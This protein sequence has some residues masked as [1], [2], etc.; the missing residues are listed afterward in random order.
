[1]DL[2]R[3]MVTI[4]VILV[5][6]TIT[7]FLIHGLILARD[8]K[9]LVEQK[10]YS[11]AEQFQS[12]AVFLLVANLAY[13]LG[14]ICMHARGVDAKPWAA[15]GLRFGLAVWLALSVP[16]FVIPYTVQPIPRSRVS[17]Q[18]FWQRF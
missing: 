7:G 2:K 17:K 11:S 16:S 12:R 8:Y 6:A 9:L 14:T 3:L 10:V 5:A 13:A 18:L 1:M 4:L 15:Q